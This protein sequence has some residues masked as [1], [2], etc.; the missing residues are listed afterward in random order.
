M[1][2]SVLPNGEC[3]AG[4]ASTYSLAL[5]MPF[6]QLLNLSLFIIALFWAGNASGDDYPRAPQKELPFGQVRVS[7]EL[8]GASMRA[9][10]LLTVRCIFYRGVAQHAWPCPER[11][12]GVS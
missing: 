12:I 4:I 7:S 2:V 5:F 8:T 9:L 1:L 10:P 6:L 3:I 11:V